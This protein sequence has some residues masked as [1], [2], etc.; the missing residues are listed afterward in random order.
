MDIT[1]LKMQVLEANLSL[2]KHGLV[3]STWG[4]ASAIDRTRGLVVIKPSGVPYDS[5]TA[6]D[7]VVVDTSGKMVEGKL[8]PSSDLP[9]HLVLYQS[10]KDVNAVVHTHSHWATIWAQAGRSIPV[11]GTTHA[12]YFYGNIPCTRKLTSAEVK[13]NYEMNTGKVIA[14]AFAHTSPVSTPGVLVHGHASFAW[15]SSCHE[16][17][18]HAVV[19]EEIARMA[20]H[21]E[22]IGSKVCLDKHIID[23]HYNRKHG[24]DAYY[25][26]K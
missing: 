8:R 12:D 6:D 1:D 26:Q 15:G 23:K 19:L 9:T 3:I 10:F 21:T 22:Q 18:H 4:N 20:F 17:I 24:K 11:Y 5:M 14:E 13:Q 7:M 25:G 16:A 2:V